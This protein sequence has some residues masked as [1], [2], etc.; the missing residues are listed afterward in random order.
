MRGKRATVAQ[1]LI[2]EVEAVQRQEGF[3]EGSEGFS[4]AV[5]HLL[6]LQLFYGGSRARQTS[7]TPALVAPVVQSSAPA[8]TP[9]A[10]KLR[11]RLANL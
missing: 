6:R 7:Q 1:G 10:S 5:N 9:A 3:A 11:E 4:E 2:G 8:P